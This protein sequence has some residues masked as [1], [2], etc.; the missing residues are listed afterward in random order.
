MVDLKNKV[1]V[2]T[3]ASSGIGRATAQ[4]F[5]RRGSRVVLVA[6]RADRLTALAERLAEEGATALPAPADVTDP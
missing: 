3:G 2:V 5:A 6:R 1:V 4:A